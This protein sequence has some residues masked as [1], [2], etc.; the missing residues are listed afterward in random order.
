MSW[1]VTPIPK[2]VL[3][4]LGDTVHRMTAGAGYSL[5]VISI[6]L[7][8]WKRAGLNLLLPPRCTF[9]DAD[10]SNNEEEKLFCLECEEGLG[11]RRWPAC[12]RCGWQVAPELDRAAD[13]PQCRRTPFGFEQVVALGD[14]HGLLGEAIL[15]MKVWQ[16]EPL[17][18]ALGDLYV[19]R[20]GAQLA[21]LKPEVLVPLPIDWLRRL[22]RRINSPD[23]LATRLGKAMGLPVVDRVLRWR[24]RTLPQKRLPPDLRFRNVRRAFR[25][26][27]GYDFHGARVALVDDVLTTGATCSEAAKALKEAG[28][29]AV[30]VATLARAARDC[31]HVDSQ[32]F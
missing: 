2:W 13:C 8:A 1:S 6:H 16:G 32:D 3:R 31:W 21:A 27:Q 20:R 9:C 5:R 4:L 15:R 30:I 28:A 12:R 24:R 26:V 14:Y 10:L 23:I 18:M 25:V 29:S 7:P 22:G 11:P 17:A 19:R